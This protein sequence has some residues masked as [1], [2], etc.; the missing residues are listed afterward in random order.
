[1]LDKGGEAKQSILVS[2][3]KRLDVLMCVKPGSYTQDEASHNFELVYFISRYYGHNR[4]F[5]VNP[6]F[7]PTKLSLAA[8]II[9]ISAQKN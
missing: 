9:Y 4:E 5:E 8:K 7:E 6:V 1:M 2:V 3:S